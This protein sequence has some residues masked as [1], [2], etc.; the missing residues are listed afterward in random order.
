VAPSAV[1]AAAGLS[2]RMRDFKPLLSLGSS[3]IIRHTIDVLRTAGADPIL[4]VTGY[5]SAVLERHL[6]SNGVMFLKNERFAQTDMLTS[7]QLGLRT[8]SPDTDRVFLT[9]ADVPLVS[10]DTLKRML[11]VRG[12]V[13]CPMYQ[14]RQGHPLL[15]D[16][17]AVSQILDWKGSGGIRGLMDTGTLEIV[18]V[19]TGDPAIRMDADTP[20]DYKR[21][22]QYQAR[23][24]GHGNLRMDLQLNI[25]MEEL[26]LTTE[27]IQLLDMI[28]QTGSIQNAC[29][30]MHISY[31]K[32]WKAVNTMERQLGFPVV[33][34]T[35]GGADGGGS[36]LTERG[37]ELLACYRLFRQK[38][39]EEALRQFDL[40]FPKYLRGSQRKG[41]K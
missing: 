36:S 38:V 7:L 6:F 9:P 40:C 29:A 3:T 18:R 22:L 20:E 15:V 4:V 27:N 14:G 23:L 13:V 35:A 24:Q 25:G 11:T 17:E 26:F 34:R 37:V 30:C 2:A 5:Q 8:L 16:R 1:I 28:G 12:Q 31:S 10:P 21:L 19:E 33:R 39:Y 41:D 32:G